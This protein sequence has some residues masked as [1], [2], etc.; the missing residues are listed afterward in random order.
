MN[1]KE[2]KYGEQIKRK[3]IRKN[4][5]S[6]YKKFKTSQNKFEWEILRKLLRYGI[7]LLTLFRRNYN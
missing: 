5:D 3:L 6:K 7:E 1:E 4:K 2:I